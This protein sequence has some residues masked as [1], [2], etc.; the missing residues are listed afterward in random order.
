MD[1]LKTYIVKR[2]AFAMLLDLRFDSMDGE[3][4][5]AVN[6]KVIISSHSVTIPWSRL[7]KD[8]FIYSNVVERVPFGRA[9]FTISLLS[10]C[11]VLLEQQ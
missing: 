11:V 6:E 1:G 9:F 8:P 5:F 3:F 2:Y 4:A 7:S 10:I